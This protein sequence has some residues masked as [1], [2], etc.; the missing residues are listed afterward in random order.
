[1]CGV[2]QNEK[3]EFTPR[4][5]SK[6]SRAVSGTFSPLVFVVNWCAIGNP[7]FLACFCIKGST[8]FL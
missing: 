5:S 2:G 6:A 4:T 1:M 8:G 7:T 3:A